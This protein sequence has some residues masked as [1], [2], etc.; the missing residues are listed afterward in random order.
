M[1]IPVTFGF[2]WT[3]DTRFI[4]PLF[5]LFCIVSIFPIIK[6]VEK[7]NYQKI[8]V[9]LIIGVILFSSVS[10]LEIKKYDQNH[11]R[12]ADYIAQYIVSIANGI[13]DY[14]PEDSYIAPSEISEKWPMLKSTINFKTKIFS[15]EGFDSLEEYIESSR[16]KG[17]TH[18]VVD[19]DKKRSDFLKDV[20]ENEDKYTYLVKQY[21]STEY[22]YSYHVKI[23]KIDYE[24]FEIYYLKQIN[25]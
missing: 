11:Q 3:Q 17:L 25:Q 19:D 2:S 5:P 24:M 16:E 15:T 12:E 14:Y 8:L 7:F 22:D 21:D 20:F 4:Y 6:F 9:I 10:Y 18:L 23:F 1:F 13:N